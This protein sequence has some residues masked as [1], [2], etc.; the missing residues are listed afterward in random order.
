M[1]CLRGLLCFLFFLDLA[2][3]YS[4]EHLDVRFLQAASVVVIAEVLEV[5]VVVIEDLSRR[6]RLKFRVQWFLLL[7]FLASL[8]HLGSGPLHKDVVHIPE[9]WLHV[10]ILWTVGI[11]KPPSGLL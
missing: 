6:Q 9:G 11:D 5:F 3:D 8:A 4:I 10:V 2:F 7:S 1:L